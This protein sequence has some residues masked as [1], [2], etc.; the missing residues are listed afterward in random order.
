MPLYAITK[1]LRFWRRLPLQLWGRLAIVIFQS[2]KCA[3]SRLMKHRGIGEH[4]LAAQWGGVK[5]K[6][7]YGGVVIGGRGGIIIEPSEAD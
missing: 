5:R 1:A 7:C 4:P 6:G 3:R 2:V